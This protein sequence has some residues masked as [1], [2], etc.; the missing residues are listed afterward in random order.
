[1]ASYYVAERE[2]VYDEREQYDA[3]YDEAFGTNPF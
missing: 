3:M 2:R 1:M